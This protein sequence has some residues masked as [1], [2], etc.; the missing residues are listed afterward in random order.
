[1]HQC[2]WSTTSRCQP[3][4]FYA[5]L[6]QSCEVG[7]SRSPPRPSPPPARAPRNTLPVE[8]SRCAWVLAGRRFRPGRCAEHAS[9]QGINS[10]R[11]CD[12][13]EVPLKKRHKPVSQGPL[14][15]GTQGDRHAELLPLPPPPPFPSVLSSPHTNPV[16]VALPECELLPLFPPRPHR[17]AVLYP[18]QVG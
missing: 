3:C 6:P 10:V 12:A 18:P 1:M 14:G 4:P 11:S 2:C 13:V 5:Q 7:A 17:S 8:P 15:A 16:P 9:K